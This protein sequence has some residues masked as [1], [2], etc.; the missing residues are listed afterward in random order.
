MFHRCSKCTYIE[1]PQVTKTFATI[2]S[3]PDWMWGAEM[4]VNEMGVA[5]GNEAVWNRL[6]DKETDLVPRLLGMDLLRFV[7]LRFLRRCMLCFATPL[8]RPTFLC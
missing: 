2:L 3:K 7:V 6:S 8:H 1:V 4:G 5:I